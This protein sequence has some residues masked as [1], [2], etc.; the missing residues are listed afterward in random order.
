MSLISQF[1]RAHEVMEYVYS[2]TGVTYPVSIRDQMN[3]ARWL[4]SQAYDLGFFGPVR[5]GDYRRLLVCGAGAAGA[6]AAIHA[7]SLGI[8]TDLVEKSA[9]PF[10][11]QRLCTSR[12]IDPVQYDWPA[13]HFT[14]GCFPHAGPGMPLDWPADRSHRLALRWQFRLAA[15]Q[16]RYPRLLKFIRG[17]WVTGA[18][19][20]VKDKAGN[21]VGV[22]VTFNSGPSQVYGMMLWCVGFGDERRFAPAKPTAQYTG[23]AFWE[24]EPF[25][26]P[27]WGVLSPPTD[28][29]DLRAL[30]SGGG[31][32]ALQDVV[33]LATTS[34]SAIDVLSTIHAA[35][36]STPADVRH[37]LFAAEDQA[38]RA[39]LWCR[40]STADAHQE[41][42]RL[43]D[44]YDKAVH[45]LTTAH[46]DR[47]RLIAGVQKILAGNP[48][49]VRL[50]YPC[51]HFNR[52]YALNHFLVLLLAKVA[53]LSN[54]PGGPFLVPQF[55]VAHVSG[56]A[57][58]TAPPNPWA[59]HGVPHTVDLDH[60]PLCHAKPPKGAAGPTRRESAHVLVI[61]HGISSHPALAGTPLA[62]AQQVMPYHLP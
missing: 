18:P 21:T 27:H 22:N 59:C 9:A 7:A 29:T 48:H 40:P 47:A 36:W 50:V 45:H 28:P 43:H 2:I 23:F 20:P 39:L 4:V 8:A 10:L 41:L 54:H 49:P 62:F 19:A 11:R 57:C 1:L 35:G 14:A 25:E 55:G 26:R 38:Q 51:T 32:G 12:W 52:C 42:Q 30:V 16:A 53:S 37:Q 31:D 6:T 61:R 58:P 46:T 5:D 15:A 3:R 24:T 17:D 13:D 44:E 34:K 56:H 60:R 33:R